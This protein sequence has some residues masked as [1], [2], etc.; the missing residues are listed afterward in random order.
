[1]DTLIQDLRYAVRQ[2]ARAP[3][4]TAVAAL[5]LAIGI[6]A[7]TALFSL[8]NAI[9]ARPLPEVGRPSGIVWLTPVDVRDG[10]ARVMSYPDFRDY[11][12]STGVFASA[13]AMG[14]AEFAISS[15]GEPTRVHG[16]LVTA[17]Y[18]RTLEVRMA[19]GRGFVAEDDRVGSRPVAVISH[20]LWQERF[21]GAIDV[22]GKRI[23]IDGRSFT[24]VGVTP[25]RFNGP[26]HSEARD[27][28]VPLALAGTAL[29]GFDGLLTSR[30]SWWLEAVAR[31]APGVSVAR[32]NAAVATVAARIARADSVGHAG[33]TARVSPMTGGLGPN[34]GNDIYPVAILAGTVTLLVLLIACAN[35]SNLL[36][37]RAVA[38]RRE[39]AI[40]LSI[41]AARSRIVRQLLTE[42]VLLAALGTAIGVLMATWATDVLAS[43]IPAPIDV[44]ADTRVLWFTIAI[45]ALTGVGFGVVPAVSAT[46]ADVTLALKDATV[47]VDRSRARLQRGFVVAQVSLSLVL[48]VTAGMFL[49]ALYKQTRVDVHFDANDRVLAAAF[50]LGLQGYSPERADAFI[51]QLRERAMA[52]PSVEAVSFTNQVPMGERHIG[53]DITLAGD[54]LA[55][56]RFGERHAVEVYESTIRP[57]YFR[58]IGIPLSRGRDFTR[59]DRVGSEPVAIVSED[60][61]RIAWPDEGAIGKRLSTNGANGPYMTVV[62]VAREALTM[63][64]TERLRPI[65]YIAQAQQPRVLDLTVLV[66]RNGNAA[67]LAPAV[68]KIMREL[69]RD[70][71]ISGVQTLG[72]YRHDRGSESRL[73]S[74][75]LAIFGTLALLLATIGVY[76]VMAFSVGQRTREIGVRVALGAARANIALM[77]VGEGLRLAAT[78]L[79]VGLLLSLAVAKVLSSLFLGLT[80]SDAITFAAGAG[81]LTLAAVSASWIPARR[82][83]R[84]DPMVALRNE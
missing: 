1:M 71:P 43:I 36:L 66:R 72:Q 7:N 70:L 54:R 28:W 46:R 13:A 45:A 30:T 25:Q 80:V 5:T 35:V 8:A 37:G 52:L 77:F 61:A 10:R 26:S 83:A 55:G 32:A 58:A 23:V 63:G 18:F 47:G 24:I 51:D 41:G 75:L 21:S 34:D 73:G 79:A 49:G 15:N 60:F 2:L 82:A 6:G 27:V 19:L 38:R 78:G 74:T 3:G 11:R 50:D 65:V 44:S 68:R 69:D 64:V 16:V 67:E 76:A 4:F 42:S 53:T 59:N 39:L 14:N 48:L 33:V 9:F 56:G 31:V 57:D 17:D 40:R 84:V 22:V 81:V 62:G 29:P 20:R 12:D